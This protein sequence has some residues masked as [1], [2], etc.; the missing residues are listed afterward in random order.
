MQWVVQARRRRIS[1]KATQRVAEAAERSTADSRAL[2][3]GVVRSTTAQTGSGSTIKTAGGAYI[4]ANVSAQHFA[5]RDLTIKNYFV[6]GLPRLVIDYSS[7]IQEFL[8]E[9]LGSN[10]KRVPFGGRGQQLAELHAWLDDPAAPPYY[11]M[12]AEAGRGKSE[13]VCRWLTQ[14]TTRPDL[15]GC[16]KS[17]SVLFSEQSVPLSVAVTH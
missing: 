5:G 16:G 17:R 14:L 12:S 9:Y 13:L 11:L 7:R 3:E 6:A 2:R 1:E 15:A 4:G 8:L 10:R